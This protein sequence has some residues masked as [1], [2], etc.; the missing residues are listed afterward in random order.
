MSKLSI[1]D[2]KEVDCDIILD[3]LRNAMQLFSS[4][5]NEWGRGLCELQLG[6]FY[7]LPSQMHTDKAQLRL[8]QAARC[9]GSIK[10]IRGI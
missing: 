1:D 8:L 4:V 7:M 10:H 2:A 9:F 6:R 5:K 3:N